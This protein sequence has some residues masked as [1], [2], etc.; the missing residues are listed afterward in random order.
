MMSWMFTQWRT[1]LVVVAGLCLA[2]A[3]LVGSL[4]VYARA[5]PEIT[6]RDALRLVP[7]LVRLVRRLTADPAVA[8][9]VRVRLVLLLIYLASPID[10]IPDVVPILGQAD[11]LVLAALVLRSVVRRAGPEALARHW[12]GS[13]AGLAV[14]RRL[15]G[16]AESSRAAVGAPARESTVDGKS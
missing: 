4:L 9:P 14:I 16:V 6:A 2:C 1:A 7:D 10:L 13:P 5:H 3:V 15:A 12:P 8:R 11:D